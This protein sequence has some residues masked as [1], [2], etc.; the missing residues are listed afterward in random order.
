MGV[1]VVLGVVGLGGR[2]GKERGVCQDRV[3]SVWRK[4]KEGH[5]VFAVMVLLWVGD[6][7]AAWIVLR[8]FTWLCMN[9][10]ETDVGR[11][12]V[13]DGYSSLIRIQIYT[14]EN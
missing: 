7:F 8:S 5:G 12:G 9:K 4:E 13:V 2:G 1:G 11:R 14:N 3:V 6:T 10:R